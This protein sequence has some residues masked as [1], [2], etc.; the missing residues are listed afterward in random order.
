[1]PAR[2][3]KA[4]HAREVVSGDKLLE[5]IESLALDTIAILEAAKSAGPSGWFPALS[6]IKRREAQ[7]ELFAKLVGEL[8]PDNNVN[9][10]FGFGADAWRELER[11]IL[12]AL[13]PFPEARQAV[14]TALLNAAHAAG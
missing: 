4:K 2:V 8:G 1:M 6:A 5:Q 3:V 14:A 7:I 10:S 11:V 9:V 12:D 13:E